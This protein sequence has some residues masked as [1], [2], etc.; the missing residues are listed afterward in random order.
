MAL[1][2]EI[3]QMQQR[4]RTRVQRYQRASEAYLR[5]FQRLGLG[6]LLLAEAHAKALELARRMLPMSLP[7]PDAS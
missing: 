2:A 5:E 3:D 6:N 1:A 7:A 4:D